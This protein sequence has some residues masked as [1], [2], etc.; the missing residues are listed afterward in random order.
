MQL[1][2]LLPILFGLSEELL[3]ILLGF[4]AKPKCFI[5]FAPIAKHLAVNGIHG[6]PPGVCVQRCI[7]IIFANISIAEAVECPAECRDKFYS[8]LAVLDRSIAISSDS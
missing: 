6:N 7:Q 8:F 4:F 2:R 3:P 5:D 1:V